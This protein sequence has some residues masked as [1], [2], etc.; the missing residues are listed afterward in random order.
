MSGFLQAGFEPR[1]AVDTSY[2]VNDKY[3]CSNVG[4]NP[5]ISVDLG[6]EGQQVSSE[7]VYSITFYQHPK[8]KSCNYQML[9]GPTCSVLPAGDYSSEGTKIGLS[10]TPAA[11]ATALWGGTLCKHYYEISDVP[12][13]GQPLTLSCPPGAGGRYLWIQAPGNNRAVVGQTFFSK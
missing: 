3:F 13:P 6:I 5:W 12:E 8:A 11:G 2:D 7:Q 10:D 9:S 4:T 1:Y